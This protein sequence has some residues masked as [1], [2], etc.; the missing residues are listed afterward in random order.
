V[1]RR[2]EVTAAIIGARNAEQARANASLA[3]APVSDAEVRAIDAIL[4]AHPAVDRPYGHGE[5][6]ART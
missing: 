5:P 3:G 1:L 2:P 4:A 6:P